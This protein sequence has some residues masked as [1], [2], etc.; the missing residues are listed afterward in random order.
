MRIFKSPITKVLFMGFL[1][2]IISTNPA[3]AALEDSIEELQSRIESISIPL[4]II[5]LIIAGWQKAMGNNYLFIAAL[6]GTV[7]IFA[8]PQLVA[9]ISTAF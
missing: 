1:F 8:A 3:F 2:G 7:I 9:F 6:I 5:F 4:A